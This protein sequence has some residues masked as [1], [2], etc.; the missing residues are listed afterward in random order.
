MRTHPRLRPIRR[1]MVL[2]RVVP[3]VRYLS[4]SVFI[5]SSETNTRVLYAYRSH[6]TPNRTPI[7]PCIYVFTV[8]HTRTRT[9]RRN[10]TRTTSYLGPPIPPRRRVGLPC[11]GHDSSSTPT[12]PSNPHEIRRR[13]IAR[14]AHST[15]S[16]E[17]IDRSIMLARTS[18]PTRTVATFERYAKTKTKERAIARARR[19]DR[20]RRARGGR[21]HAWMEGADR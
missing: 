20:W 12:H 5:I 1:R 18:V 21:G 9:H 8:S 3:N 7:S 15:S 2:R 4:P 11:A 19:G 17:A 6:H 10:H 13:R 14:A 16:R